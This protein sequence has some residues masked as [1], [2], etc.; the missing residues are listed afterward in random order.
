MAAI[1]VFWPELVT[2]AIDK[3]PTIDPD[4]IT[5]EVPMI[6]DQPPAWDG[7]EAPNP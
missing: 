6:E 3:A 4:S 1:I 2:F 7:G 5:I